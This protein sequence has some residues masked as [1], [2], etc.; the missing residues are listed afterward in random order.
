MEGLQQ[1]EQAFSQMLSGDADTQQQ[2]D[3]NEQTPQKNMVRSKR[4]KLKSTKQSQH[5][6]L[7]DTPLI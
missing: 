5:Q 2:V 4:V 3:E 1:A 6:N 7:N